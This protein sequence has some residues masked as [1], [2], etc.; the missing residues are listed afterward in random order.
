MV[1]R[2]NGSGR[3][4]YIAS[5]SGGFRL[6]ESNLRNASFNNTLRNEFPNLGRSKSNRNSPGRKEVTK[7]NWYSPKVQ[8]GLRMIHTRQR[9]MSRELSVPK[10]R[11]NATTLALKLEEMNKV[12]SMKRSKLNRYM[13]IR[14]SPKIN[15]ISKD[16]KRSKL[17]IT[18]R[19]LS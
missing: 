7:V 1:Y 19:E 9:Q 5:N 13:F 2:H 11:E 18:R 14:K 3:D 15:R 6:D 4:T 16:D 8:K 12:N 10:S 17:L